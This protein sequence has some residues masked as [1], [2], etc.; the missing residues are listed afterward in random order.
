[1]DGSFVSQGKAAEADPMGGIMDLMK[2]NFSVPSPNSMS[3][4]RVQV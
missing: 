4:S 2:V 3:S 1:M